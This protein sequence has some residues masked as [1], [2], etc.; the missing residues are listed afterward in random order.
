MGTLKIWLNKCSNEIF[1]MAVGFSISTEFAQKNL[2][3]LHLRGHMHACM[4]C[5]NAV[6]ICYDYS[7]S[8]PVLRCDVRLRLESFLHSFGLA[9]HLAKCKAI[10]YRFIRLRT[11]ASCTIHHGFVSSFGGSPHLQSLYLLS[12]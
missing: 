5:I 11:Y 9:V 7:P 12:S 10:K 2:A 4:A 1:E 8:K 6:E 3:T